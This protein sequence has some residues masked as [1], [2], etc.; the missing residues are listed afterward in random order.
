MSSLATGAEEDVRHWG[1]SLF[2]MQGDEITEQ[3][4]VKRLHHHIPISMPK[5]RSKNAPENGN[6]SVSSS[7]AGKL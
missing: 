7:V 6:F 2:L 4:H 3:D 1:K 5:I